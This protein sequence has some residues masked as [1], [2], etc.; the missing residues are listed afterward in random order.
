MGQQQLLLV[1][2][3]AIIVGIAVVIGIQMFEES[4]VTANQ[5]AVMQD[6]LHVAT[7]AREWYRKPTVMGGGGQAFTGLTLASLNI[8]STNAN[9]TIRIGTVNA[10]DFNITGIGIEGTPLTVAMTVYNDS[11]GTPTITQ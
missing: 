7:R 1:V 4:A 9:G 8:D 5:D 6:V 10:N 3:S 11:L 2:L